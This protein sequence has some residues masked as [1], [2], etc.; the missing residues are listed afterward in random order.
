MLACNAHENAVSLGER[1]GEGSVFTGMK[2]QRTGV[3]DPITSVR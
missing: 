3:S 1:G 2:A